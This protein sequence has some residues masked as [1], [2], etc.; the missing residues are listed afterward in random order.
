MISGSDRVGE[1]DGRTMDDSAG[2]D[3]LSR[4]PVHA[5]FWL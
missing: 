4:V 1:D 2:G 3:Q 5:M